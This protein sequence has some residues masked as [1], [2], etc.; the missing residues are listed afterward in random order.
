MSKSGGSMS[1]SGPSVGVSGS[2][3][4]SNKLSAQLALSHVLSRLSSSNV[5]CSAMVSMRSEAT[6]DDNAQWDDKYFYE[7]PEQIQKPQDRTKTLKK[8]SKPKKKASEVTKEELTKIKEISKCRARSMS[9]AMGEVAPPLKQIDNFGH[10]K[11][12]NLWEKAE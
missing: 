7:P 5:D 1:R 3:Q 11:R 12:S 6:L 10:G 8:P 9:L 2:S 4:G